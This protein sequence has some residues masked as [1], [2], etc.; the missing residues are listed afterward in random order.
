M[1]IKRFIGKSWPIKGDGA[2]FVL[3]FV[4]HNITAQF[5]VHGLQFVVYSA[6]CTILELNLQCCTAVNCIISQT[7]SSYGDDCCAGDDEERVDDDDEEHVDDDDDDGD[8][9]EN[10]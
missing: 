4:V 7:M 10:K 3:Q 1:T 6:Q 8:D 9:N 2:E 5:A